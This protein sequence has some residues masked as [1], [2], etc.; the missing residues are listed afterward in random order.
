M[1]KASKHFFDD[2]NLITISND[3]NTEFICLSD[4]VIYVLTDPIDDEEKITLIRNKIKKLSFALSR[5]FKAES[6]DFERH[7][8]MY[9]NR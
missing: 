1:Y 4:F 9:R 2:T 3:T 5:F 8:K 6:M 7:E